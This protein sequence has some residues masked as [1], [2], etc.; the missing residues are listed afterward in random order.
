MRRCLWLAFLLPSA[1]SP[2]PPVQLSLSA[3][4][5]LFEPGQPLAV[6]A[7]VR[8]REGDPRTVRL[9][10]QVTDSRG[11][12]LTGGQV[13]CDAR[14]DRDTEVTLRAE[15]A[16]APLREHLVAHVT[17]YPSCGEPQTFG[18]L[19]VPRPT[20]FGLDE[21]SPFA[22]LEGHPYTQRRLGA[23]WQRPNFSW[24]EREMELAKRYGV[25]Y[26]ALVNQANAALT[27]DM[28]LDEYGAFVEESVRRFRHLVKY[29][30]LGNE[31]NLWQPGIPE[32][33]AEILEVGYEAA[34]RADPQ[35]QVLWGGITGLDVTPRWWTSSWPPAAAGTRTSSMSTCTSPSP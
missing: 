10:L 30:Q 22:V 20:D 29:W 1:A 17:S 4:E 33:W 25:N 8:L 26:V 21:T 9:L 12:P 31:P 6:R 34:K 5:R 35:C 28:S 7:S 24:N 32:R 19:V 16:G 13:D 11:R 18:L 2:Q 27:E 14:A 15:P 23:G 3:A